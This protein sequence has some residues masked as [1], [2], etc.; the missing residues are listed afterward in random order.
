MVLEQRSA[1]ALGPDSRAGVAALG[2]RLAGEVTFDGV[3]KIAGLFA[4]VLAAAAL[5]ALALGD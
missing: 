5:L 4:V 1:S 2:G 3:G